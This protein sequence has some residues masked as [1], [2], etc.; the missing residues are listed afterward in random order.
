MPLWN[1][2]VTL[3][4]FDYTTIDATLLHVN[5]YEQ[6]VYELFGIPNTNFLKEG[7]V[8][9]ASHIF[10]I[11]NIARNHGIPQDVI[12]DKLKL[13]APTMAKY[14]QMNIKDSNITILPGVFEILKRLQD[15]Q[16]LT[17]VLT[18]NY[19]IVADE[20]LKKTKMRGYF[21][22]TVTTDDSIDRKERMRIAI[23]QAEGFLVRKIDPAR[24]YF[25][26]DSNGGIADSREVGIR[27]VSVAKNE[28]EYSKLKALGPYRVVIGLENTNEILKILGLV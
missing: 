24:V 7:Y 6:T 4:D 14:Y 19:S 3:W 25:F 8:P 5:T 9:G 18:G 1:D 17:G 22:F 10:T 15:F 23:R 12:N 27:H 16:V 2:I 11:R 21:Q 28:E 13:V 20:I 26:D